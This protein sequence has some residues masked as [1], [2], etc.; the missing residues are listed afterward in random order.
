MKFLLSLL[1]FLQTCLVLPAQE[2]PAAGAGS[3]ATENATRPNILFISVDDLN[4][5]I[6]PLAGHP[7][8]LTP[9]FQRLASQS[10]LFTNAH[11]PA[12]ACGPCRAAILSGIA[13]HRSGLYD[14]MQP[15]REVMPDVTLMPRHF[16]N[17]GYHAAG[18]GKIL[19]YVIDPRSWHDYFPAKEKDN[20]FPRTLYPEKRPV[21]LPR[22]GPWQYVETDWGPLDV[23]DEEFGG[24]YSVSQWISK[25]LLEPPSEKP[26]FLACGLYRPHEP[27][28]VPAKYF[29]PFPLDKVQLPPGYRPDDLDDVPPAGRAM[30]RNRYF[31]HIQWQGEWRAAVQGYLAS[32]HFAD[33]MLGNVLDALEKS[34]RR[35]NTIVVLWSDH[36]WHLGEKEHWQK[37]TGWRACTRV[38]LMIRGPQITSGI[39]DQPVSTIDLFR[40]LVSLSGIPERENITGHDLTPLLKNPAAPWP[41]LA[42]TQLR[43]P[44]S[45]AL[46][47]KKFRYLHYANDDEELYDISADP[48]EL[49]N[50]AND[51]TH[52]ATL[53][54]FREKAPKNGVPKE[55]ATLSGALKNAPLVQLTTTANPPPSRPSEDRALIGIRN[56]SDNHLDLIWID[57]NGK[58]KSFGQVAKASNRLLKTKVGHTW[59]VQ[60]KEGKSLGHLIVP[61]GGARLLI[62]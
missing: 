11:C 21:S 54:S 23:T 14:N 34:P 50:L 25:Q 44:K 20:P 48:Y 45:Y 56:S 30:A 41:H 39:C 36:G 40:T 10:V 28:F 7:Q 16:A 12:P 9:N 60:N 46:S 59:L 1:L 58:G 26:F 55:K 53:V 35:E 47:G 6:S 52:A 2:D 61:K 5:W 24:D 49:K 4:D 32:I 62:E 15:L 22:G 37:F 13:P 57:L 43:G 27:W 8:T 29:E 38:P 51:P 17:H 3:K 31:P 19:H 42:L 33:A 18:S